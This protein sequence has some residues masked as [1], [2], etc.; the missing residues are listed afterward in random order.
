MGEDQ[1]ND[2]ELDGPIALSRGLARTFDWGDGR[3]KPQ[4]TCN[5]VIRNF[6][7]SNFLWGKDI[8]EKKIISCGLL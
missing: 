2:L 6:R 5:G 7:K 3:G 4:I 1:L 8:V